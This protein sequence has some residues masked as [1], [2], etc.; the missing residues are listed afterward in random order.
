MPES[1]AEAVKE[2]ADQGLD[3]EVAFDD[4]L[5]DELATTNSEAKRKKFVKRLK[6]SNPSSSLATGR[7]G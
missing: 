4:T 1:G 2:L 6:L 7:N 3:L 5:R